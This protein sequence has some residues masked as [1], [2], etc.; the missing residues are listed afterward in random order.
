[1]HVVD[2]VL[3]QLD[4]VLLDC[5]PCPG[6]I[7]CWVRIE[8]CLFMPVSVSSYSPL[9]NVLPR[10]VSEYDPAHRGLGIKRLFA[11]LQYAL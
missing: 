10:S 5:T 8:L 9:C 3:G 1:M 2:V 4:A 7:P 11:D 6:T